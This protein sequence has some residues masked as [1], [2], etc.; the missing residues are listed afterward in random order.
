[1]AV[2]VKNTSG[3]DLE[4]EDFGI[5]LIASAQRT[6]SDEFELVDIAS[7]QQLRDLVSSGDITINDG[8]QDLSAADGL[9]AVTIESQYEDEANDPSPSGWV[10]GSVAPG[11][12][13]DGDG[14]FNTGDKLLYLWDDLRGAWLTSRWNTYFGYLWNAQNRYLF[15]S[16]YHNDPEGHVALI[17]PVTICAAHVAINIRKA[18]ITVQIQLQEDYVVRGSLPVDASTTGWKRYPFPVLDI[19]FDAGSR[20]QMY[21]SATGRVVDPF[22]TFECAW[23][24]VA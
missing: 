22:V 8:T 4:L 14:W 20:M 3:G 23:R 17:R 1:M 13:S 18:G 15:P 16:A 21:C 2:I 7:S 6:L 10:V 12:P 24:Y 5:E 11:S 9:K 19:D